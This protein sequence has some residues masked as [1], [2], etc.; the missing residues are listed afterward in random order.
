MVVGGIVNAQR[1]MLHTLCINMAWCCGE[2]VSYLLG[3]FVTSILH[4]CLMPTARPFP[5]LVDRAP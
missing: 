5:L 2:P 3:H 4:H 1:T